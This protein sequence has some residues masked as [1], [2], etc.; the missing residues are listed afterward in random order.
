[1]SS[2]AVIVRPLPTLG[3]AGRSEILALWDRLDAEQQAALIIAAR[4]MVEKQEAAQIAK[5]N[6]RD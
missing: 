5:R 4:G 2:C 3:F 6:G 1:M